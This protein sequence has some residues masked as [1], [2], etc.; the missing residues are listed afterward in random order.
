MKTVAPLSEW[1]EE[2]FLRLAVTVVE[3]EQ[4]E[5]ERDEPWR[6]GYAERNAAA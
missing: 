1:G 2:E 6:A 4:Q 3:R 5:M